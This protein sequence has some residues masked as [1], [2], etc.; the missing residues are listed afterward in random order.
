MG[1]LS[2]HCIELKNRRGC[3]RICSFLNGLKP[4]LVM[5]LISVL[6]AVLNILYKLV[7]NDGMNLRIFVAYRVILAA[8]LMVPL[9][10]VV[11][12][13]KRPKLTWIILVQAFLCG[14]FG[15][16][17]SLN[18]YMESVALVS[19]TYA[20]AMSNM[21]PAITFV[22]A[23]CLRMEKLAIRSVPAVAK[24]VGSLVGIGGATV[25]TLYKGIKIQIWSTSPHLLRINQNT[26]S[27]SQA[28]QSSNPALGYVL[29]ILGCFC[30]ATWY[31]IQGKM[32]KTYPC[33]FSC[34]A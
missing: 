18:L 25:F 28:H 5:L 19:A 33:V 21:L 30:S 24:V 2:K 32:S 20:A 26:S 23:V 31:I 9:A 34:T 4:V 8:V 13:N 17:L 27:S 6:G 7:A 16:I 14:L 22:M 15:T 29:S 3:E 12:R 11:E 10:F 1:S